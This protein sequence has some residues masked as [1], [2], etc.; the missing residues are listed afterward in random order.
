MHKAISGTIMFFTSIAIVGALLFGIAAQRGPVFDNRPRVAKVEMIDYGWGTGGYLGGGYFLTAGHVADGVHALQI[1]MPDGT[2]LPATVLWANHDEDVALL[3]V[4]AV[5]A[6]R[7]FK[8]S[9][10]ACRLPIKGEPITAEGFP[11][12]FNDVVFQGYV[13]GDI[14]SIWFWKHAIPMNIVGNHGISGGPVFDANGAILGVFVGG[15]TPWGGMT[16]SVSSR[17]VCD[18]MG[19]DKIGWKE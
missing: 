11:G 8:R 13:A 4:D 3:H 7:A 14:T 1:A 12:E 5:I 15:E 17:E 19:L 16:V 9:P 18:L 2:K 10:L 6:D